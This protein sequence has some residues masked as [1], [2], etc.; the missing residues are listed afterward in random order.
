MCMPDGDLGDLDIG[1]RVE[2]HADLTSA[3]QIYKTS[4]GHGSGHG[5][6]YRV[7]L[8][9]PMFVDVRISQSGDQVWALVPQISPLAACDAADDHD[10]ICIDPNNTGASF[11]IGPQQ[12]GIYYVIV[13][14]FSSGSE[15]TVD[16][17][18]S[19]RET[20]TLEICNNGI[21]DDGD[22]AVDCNDRK[23]VGDVECKKLR[24]QPDEDLGLVPLDGSTSIKAVDT[25]RAGDAQHQSA[26]VSGSGGQDVV[27]G[28][29]LPGPT[30]LTVGWLEIGSHAF[31]LYQADVVPLPCEANKPVDCHAASG[32]GSG[33]YVLPGLA[34]GKYFLVV[35]ADK[36]GSEGAVIL[37][38]SGLPSQ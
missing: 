22:G 26:C 9:S 21:D 15:G 29:E 8:L 30:D 2:L 16:V 36:A 3:T 7:N 35:D 10:G 5:R 12:P 27:V 13:A 31:V 11:F 14:G 20:G 1:G 28:F 4:C 23:C 25:S 32:A 37:Q 34:A 17:R 33:S 19:G 6:A 18:M 24:C 38:V